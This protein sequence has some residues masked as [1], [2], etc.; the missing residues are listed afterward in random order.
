MPSVVVVVA[1]AVVIVV[2][3]YYKQQYSKGSSVTRV[4]N[5]TNSNSRHMIRVMAKRR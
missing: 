5:S 3:V 4:V 2:A 1:A